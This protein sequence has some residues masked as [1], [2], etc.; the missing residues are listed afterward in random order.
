[1]PLPTLKTPKYELTIPSTKEKIKFRP[2]LVKEE[3]IL[4]M[5]AESQ[6]PKEIVEA[7]RNV[8][9]TCMDSKKLD[10]S[11]LPTFDLE[12]I[13]LKLRS[14][15][16]GETVEATVVCEECGATTP[17]SVDLS[18]V[19]IKYSDGHESK[20]EFT[21]DIGVIMRYPNFEMSVQISSEE[22]SI[23]D[24]VTILALCID[25][26]YDKD[27][28]YSRNDY[29]DDEFEEFVLSMTQSE[30]NKMK[31]FFDTMPKMEHTVHLKCPKCEKES[32]IVLR[33]LN[34]FFT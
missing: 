24:V 30:V 18:S 20:I 10:V 3:K 28:I 17:C 22:E 23:E 25:K 13:F 33:N 19:E 7:L 11:S 26:I 1:M 27:N 29:S 31:M 12:Y 9:A 34:D 21:K 2:F 14:K 4:L 8:F 16:V 5:A 6:N 32:D 15:S